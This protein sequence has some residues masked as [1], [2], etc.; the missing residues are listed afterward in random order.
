MTL[1]LK[2]QFTSLGEKDAP[3]FVM[4]HGYGYNMQVMKIFERFLPAGINILYFEAPLAVMPEKE[5]REGRLVPR[6]DVA[7]A[8]RNGSDNAGSYSWWPAGSRLHAD[9]PTKELHDSLIEV[10]S[11]YQLAPENLNFVGFSQGAGMIFSMLAN[12]SDNSPLR[13]IPIKNIV[14]MVG[15]IPAG[16]DNLSAAQGS[17]ILWVHG[18]LDEVVP[19][20]EAE[21]AQQFL[22]SLGMNFELLSEEVGHKL[23]VK[24]FRFLKERL[25]VK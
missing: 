2:Y 21:R 4:L 6:E 13:A 1:M 3:I 5:L 14:S 23:G 18:T 22:T 24:G 25:N 9:A 11:T 8:A 16:I 20:L 12:I 17:Q 15:F 7:S 10:L 19:Y